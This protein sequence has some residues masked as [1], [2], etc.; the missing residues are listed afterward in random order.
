MNRATADALTFDAYDCVLAV[1]PGLLVSHTLA[2]YFGK[3]YSRRH[4]QRLQISSSPELLCG[5]VHQNFSC[6]TASAS[7]ALQRPA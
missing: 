5:A 4:W 6:T 2:D 1:E 7:D 3:N